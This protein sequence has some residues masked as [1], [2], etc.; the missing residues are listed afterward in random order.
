MDLKRGRGWVRTTNHTTQTHTLFQ[1]GARV[2]RRASPGSTTTGPCERGRTRRRA[3]PVQSTTL[4]P[5]S[6]V[7]SVTRQSL[8]TAVAS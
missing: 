8:L 2:R 1:K 6:C 4:S 3:S 5:M 7:S